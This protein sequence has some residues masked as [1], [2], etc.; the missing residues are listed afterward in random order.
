MRLSEETV[1]AQVDPRHWRVRDGHL[2]VTVATGSF[3][4]GLELVTA[5]ADLAERLGHH[6]DVLLTYPSVRLTS[7]SHDV[8]GLTLRDV[9]LAR[10]VSALLDEQGLAVIE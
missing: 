5:V 2:E 9:E 6:P 1:A 8:G 10:A 7:L 3:L 4:R